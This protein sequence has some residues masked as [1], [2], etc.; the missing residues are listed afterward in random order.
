M[1]M[2]AAQ[3][4]LTL[5]GVMRVSWFLLIGKVPGPATLC[6]RSYGQLILKANISHNK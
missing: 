6:R 4:G 5:K 1:S 3:I 2:M